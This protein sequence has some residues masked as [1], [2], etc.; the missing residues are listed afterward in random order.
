M[1]ISDWSSDVCSS[2]LWF[3]AE[4]HRL[5]GECLYALAGDR[6]EQAE[7][8][9][10]RA[11]AVGRSQDARMWELRAAATLARLWR[12]QGKQSQARDLPAPLCGRFTEGFATPDLIDASALLETLQRHGGTPPHKLKKRPQAQRPTK[13][14]GTERTRTAGGKEG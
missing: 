5:K 7:D 3:E 4:L 11:L 13:D 1:R 14:T 9:L 12:A 6:S 2:D 10:R 8:R